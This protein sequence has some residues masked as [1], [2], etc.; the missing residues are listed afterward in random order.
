MVGE[1]SL[2]KMD[3]SRGY[4]KK[5]VISNKREIKRKPDQANNMDI[6]EEGER[7]ARSR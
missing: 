4:T 6:Q 2:T 7:S 5:S 3:S 1:K